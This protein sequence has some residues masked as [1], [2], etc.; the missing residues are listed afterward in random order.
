MNL[1][2]ISI[3]TRGLRTRGEG[4]LIFKSMIRFDGHEPDVTR[5]K[6]KGDKTR[7]NRC[8]PLSIEFYKSIIIRSG[9]KNKNKKKKKEEK[10]IL[11]YLFIRCIFYFFFFLIGCWIMIAVKKKEGGSGWG[12][13]VN[14]KMKRNDRRESEK[15]DSLVRDIGGEGRGRGRNRGLLKLANRQINPEFLPE[16]NNT[17]SATGVSAN[18][19]SAKMRKRS[20]SSSGQ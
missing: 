16:N 20:A 13:D 2:C 11:S 9:E 19:L 15:V 1:S 14:W 3:R 10:K 18:A 6:I 8:K 7:E 5:W 12:R 17:S 4:R